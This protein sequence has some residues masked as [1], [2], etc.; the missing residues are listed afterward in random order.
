MSCITVE[1]K[2]MEQLD[3]GLGRR[4]LPSRAFTLVELLVVIAIIG[5]LVALL[6]PAVQAAREAARRTT[7]Q[8]Q[9]RQLSLGSMNHTDVAGHYPTG[10]W[11]W[12]WLG[13]ADRGFGPDQPGG[14]IYNILP[15]IEEQNKYNL[16]SD[17]DPSSVTRDQQRGAA[18]LL[19][20]P[21]TILNCPSRR[22]NQLWQFSPPEGKFPKNA[23]APADG[24]VARGD[25]AMNSGSLRNEGSFPDG[26]GPETWED[27]PDFTGWL[28][29]DPTME[30]ELNGISFQRSTVRIAQITDGTSNTYMIGERYIPASVIEEGTFSGDNE[31]WVTG[32]N[33]DNYRIGRWP[34]ASDSTEPAGMPTTVQVGPTTETVGGNHA[35]T[36]FG[37]SHPSV[38]HV[39]FCDGSVRG[40][41]YDI[42]LLT[43]RN[44]SNRADGVPLDSDQ[45]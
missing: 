15:F 23:R 43:H 3:M 14:W 35:A 16:P 8:S 12:L 33:N 1:K 11:G 29:E 41:S 28:L 9:V 13:D 36:R 31:T 32:F 19:Q 34:P 30:E 38:W 25:Y 7:C 27:V 5:V 20:Q 26:R 4:A 21:I 17:G 2:E 42:D 39:S 18:L 24:L 45:Y 44:L 37:S 10:G 40:I 6:L 22:T